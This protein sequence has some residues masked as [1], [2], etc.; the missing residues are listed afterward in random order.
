MNKPAYK[1]ISAI[2][3]VKLINY[4]DTIYCSIFLVRLISYQNSLLTYLANRNWF[5][6]LLPIHRDSENK[7]KTYNSTLTKWTKLWKVLQISHK[8]TGCIRLNRHSI[9]W[10]NLCNMLRNLKIKIML[11]VTFYFDLM[12]FKQLKYNCFLD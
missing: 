9:Y 10:Q 12:P 3:V 2:I 7:N 8:S 5:S 6:H 1:W 11:I 4:N